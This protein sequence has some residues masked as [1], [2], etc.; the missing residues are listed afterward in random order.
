MEWNF[1]NKKISILLSIMYAL[2][3][4]S[5]YHY[6]NKLNHINKLFLLLFI[7]YVIS[8]GIN[9]IN[10]NLTCNINKPSIW[11]LSSAIVAPI[12]LL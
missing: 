1:I 7:T 10:P 4:I 9:I 2:I 3:F 6:N 5:V 12:M 8:F 11:C